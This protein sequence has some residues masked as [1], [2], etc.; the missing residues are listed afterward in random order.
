MPPNF[1]LAIFP[2]DH[3]G[4]PIRPQADK[5]FCVENPYTDLFRFSIEGHQSPT[6]PISDCEG[7]AL[8]NQ[9]ADFARPHWGSNFIDNFVRY[10]LSCESDGQHWSVTCPSSGNDPLE[11]GR[12]F[13]RR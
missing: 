4:Q 2:A 6:C 8:H 11:D 5:I 1:D 12:G 13:R 7:G 9:F 10:F 3:F